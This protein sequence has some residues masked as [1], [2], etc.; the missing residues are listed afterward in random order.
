MIRNGVFVSFAFTLNEQDINTT[1]RWGQGF[2]QQ[3]SPFGLCCF[4]SLDSIQPLWS[5]PGALHVANYILH[6]VDD[7]DHND[8]GHPQS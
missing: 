7:K 4:A 6:L 2:A 3:F 8:S 1:T 5:E